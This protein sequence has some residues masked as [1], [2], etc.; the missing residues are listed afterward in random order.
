MR[1]SV[2]NKARAFAPGE[3]QNRQKSNVGDFQGSAEGTTL[4]TR[5]HQFAP[6]E[7]AVIAFRATEYVASCSLSLFDNFVY[8]Q[9][10]HEICYR[11]SDVQ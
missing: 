8:S 2:K 1:Y 4:R 7:S 3:L 10:V 11:V 6:E 9:A 5:R